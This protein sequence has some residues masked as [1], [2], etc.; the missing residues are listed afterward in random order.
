MSCNETQPVIPS[1]KL[2]LRVANLINLDD[3]DSPDMR[4]IGTYTWKPDIP[5]NKYALVQTVK[6]SGVSDSVSDLLGFYSRSALPNGVQ[7]K[8]N[9]GG[10]EILYQTFK[11]TVDMLKYSNTG[12]NQVEEKRDI[13]A[14]VAAS[15]QCEPFNIYSRDDKIE[16]VIQDDLSTM[17]YFQACV[18]YVEV[19]I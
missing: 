18:F 3:S 12:S 11:Q 13:Q 8:W 17:I 15:I 14:S 10:N 9:V 2:N 1:K 16:V 19:D 7:L 6:L 4:S 5:G